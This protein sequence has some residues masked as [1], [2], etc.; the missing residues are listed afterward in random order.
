MAPY[1]AQDPFGAQAPVQAPPLSVQGPAQ[2]GRPAP[3]VRYRLRQ[4]EAGGPAVPAET[5]RQD[6]VRQEQEL[7]ASEPAGLGVSLMAPSPPA[8]APNALFGGTDDLVRAIIL[9][10]ILGPPLS[11]RKPSP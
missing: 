8:A 7:F 4:P 6:F 5:N 2:A 3:A 10:E 9:Q 11:R 1:Q